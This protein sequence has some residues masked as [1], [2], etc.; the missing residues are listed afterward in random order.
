MTTYN[1]FAKNQ[2]VSIMK[3]VVSLALALVLML[4]ASIPVFAAPSPTGTYVYVV[5]VV[6]TPGGDGDYEFTTDI[7]EDGNQNVHVTP[8][9]KPGY[10]FDHWVIEGPY[11]TNQPL[12]DKELD[13]IIT[14]D[15]K[16][17]PYF[18]KNGESP[19]QSVTTDTSSKSPQTGPSNSMPYVI[20]G[21]S[22]L[23]VAVSV[24]IVKSKKSN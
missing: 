1:L 20:I 4:A 23:A 9:P 7:D 17:T 5:I 8:K 16:V 22:L 12:T 15:I 18:T 3:K 13:L 21:L 10:T 24:T 11:R 2:E 14:G 6:P 19:T